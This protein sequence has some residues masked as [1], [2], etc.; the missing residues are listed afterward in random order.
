MVCVTARAH[1][2]RWYGV[3]R[4]SAVARASMLAPCGVTV[5]PCPA[6]YMAAAKATRAAIIVRLVGTRFT[7]GWGGPGDSRLRLWFLFGISACSGGRRVDVRERDAPPSRARPTTRGLQRAAFESATRRLRERDQ[8]H[9]A[10]NVPPSRARRAAFESAINDTRPARSTTRGLQ[11]AAFESAA[12]RLR[13][14]DQRHEAFNA[15][16]PSARGAPPASSP[17]SPSTSGTSRRRRA[18][19]TRVLR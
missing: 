6:K 12:R 18:W 2:R 14:R 5:E 16:R 8:R 19:P 11:R 4:V 17:S 15:A 3:R 7:G 10:F 13:E 1:A 9:E